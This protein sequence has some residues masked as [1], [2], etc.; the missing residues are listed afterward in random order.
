ME[1]ISCGLK[2]TTPT[3]NIFGCA[4]VPQK[5]DSCEQEF[6]IILGISLKNYVLANMNKGAVIRKLLLYPMI[7][8]KTI[9]YIPGFQSSKK[10]KY[11]MHS[12]IS[13]ISQ[14]FATEGHFRRSRPHLCQNK[15]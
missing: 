11:L 13:Q 5:A 12:C 4:N 3:S 9:R 8:K 10:L 14:F 6:I 1:H 15:A 2:E 7:L